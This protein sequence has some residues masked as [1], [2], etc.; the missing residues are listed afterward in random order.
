[1]TTLTV[2][3]MTQNCAS[4]KSGWA[5]HRC[6]ILSDRIHTRLPD[7]LYT[8]ETYAAQRDRLVTALADEYHLGT[9][10]QGRCVFYRPA[11]FAK[12]SGSDTHFDLPNS[13]AA[14]GVKVEHRTT[15]KRFNLVAAHLTWQHDRESYRAKETEALVTKV[16]AA[17]PDNRTIY[18]G[19]W[20]DSLRFGD[21]T[22]DAVGR[23]M[24][25][26]G[27]RDL[28]KDVPET[29]RAYDQY[30]S[31]NQFDLTPPQDG[32][33]LDRFFGGNTTGARW[34]LDHYAPTTVAGY[35]SDHYGVE[36]GARITL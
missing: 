27:Y 32:I 15:G 6:R 21:R 18:A 24:A 11:V 29:L 12:V 9:A 36:I 26:H 2:T 20:N 13:K 7:A 25:S 30:N 31:A 10:Y 33:H 1:M 19:D 17:Y 28:F 34:R 23:V 8:V 22:G 14:A 16:K 4:A 35:G 3:L 5:D